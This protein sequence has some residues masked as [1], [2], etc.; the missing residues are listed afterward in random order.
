[1]QMFGGSATLSAP[2]GIITTTIPLTEASYS[3]IFGF[4]CP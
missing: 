3:G 2:M 1:M 4:G